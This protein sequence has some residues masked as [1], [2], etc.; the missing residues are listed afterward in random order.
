MKQVHLSIFC[1]YFA[2]HDNT[3]SGDCGHPDTPHGRRVSRGV[4]GRVCRS[5]DGPAAVTTPAPEPI[6]DDYEPTASNATRGGCGC[7]K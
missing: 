5:Y 1:R 2:A 3:R 4:C 7:K 6:P